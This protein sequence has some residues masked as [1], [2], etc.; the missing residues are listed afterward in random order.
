MATFCLNIFH[1]TFIE[2][3]VEH[4][5]DVHLNP[6]APALASLLKERKQQAANNKNE[7]N[8]VAIA[9]AA[10][11]PINLPDQPA[12]AQNN[13][14]NDHHHPVHPIAGLDC[15]AHGGPTDPNAS[16][17]LVYWK[18]LPLDSQYTSPFRDPNKRRYL[19]FEPDGGGWNNIRMSME[20]VLG[21]AIATGRVL[22]LPPSQK[23]YLLGQDT[24]SFADFFPLHDIAQEHDGLEILSM[25]EFLEETR[26]T[27]RLRKDG[28]L[29]Q[30][31]NN[32]TEW[33]GDTNGVKSML[34][35][36]LQSIAE[37]PD[38]DPTKCMAGE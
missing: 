15:T 28:S 9:A 17:E 35:P 16:R 14:N 27:L 5:H 22:V 10:H 2:H 32:V 24:F 18:D 21:M 7:E 25:K 29:A 37:L 6:N 31:P 4:F 20:T 36:F 8:P 23:M 3:D 34:N 13:I 11:V 30:I 33:D 26:G 38:W 1:G 12:V 19:T